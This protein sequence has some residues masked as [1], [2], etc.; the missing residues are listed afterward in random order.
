VRS[1]GIGVICIAKRGIKPSNLEDRF[2]VFNGSHMHLPE[3]FI[4]RRASTADLETLVAHRRAMFRDMGHHDELRLNRMS[5]KFRAWLL[6]HM[7]SGD[8]HAWLIA[9]ADGSIAAGA[10]L[11]LMDWPPHI[12]GQGTQRANIVNVYTVQIYRR[13]GLARHLMEAVLHWCRENHIDTI[14]LHASP[15][16]RALY[17]S[18]GFMPTNEMRLLL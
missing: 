9:V 7:N 3:G 12:M 2:Q 1:F 8:Y 13:R 4:V 16:G 15:S 17:E 14:I 18:M 6:E 5:A 10:G 11:W